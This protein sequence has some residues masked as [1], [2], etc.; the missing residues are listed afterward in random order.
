MAESSSSLFKNSF[1][2]F[3]FQLGKSSTLRNIMKG[4]YAGKE[5][6]LVN[7]HNSYG[8]RAGGYIVTIVA[9]RFLNGRFNKEVGTL[10]N[11][12]FEAREPWII[13]SKKL[14]NF[15]A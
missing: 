13:V 7:Y 15:T 2:E 4:T 11:L 10:N 12:R 6:F 14:S 8:Y 5:T 9:F 3:P 1:P